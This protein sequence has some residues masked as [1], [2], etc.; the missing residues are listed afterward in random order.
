[1]T[2]D[3]MLIKPYFANE[4]HTL[5]RDMLLMVYD[6]KSEIYDFTHQSYTA[7]SHPQF[8]FFVVRLQ[9]GPQQ[10]DPLI[11]LLL[12]LPLQLVFSSTRSGFAERK[13]E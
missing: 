10:G 11:P 8:G 5:H 3:E 4:F 1:M 9:M 7:K 13:E 6:A 12:C 2:E